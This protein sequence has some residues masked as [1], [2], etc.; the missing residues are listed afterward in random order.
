LPIEISDLKEFATE[1]SS[2]YFE[3]INTYFVEYNKLKKN[4]SVESIM[5]L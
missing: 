3:A 1:L 5:D 4:R 2:Q